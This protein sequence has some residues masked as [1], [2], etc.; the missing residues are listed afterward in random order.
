VPFNPESELTGTGEWVER[1]LW[2]GHCVWVNI[3]W[4]LAIGL[5]EYGY[6]EEAREMTARVVHMILREG[7]FEYYDSRS[8]EGRRITDFCWPALALDMMARFWPQA[9]GGES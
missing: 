3:S 8:G 2:S 6:V 9:V 4:M 1:H 7:F 5:G